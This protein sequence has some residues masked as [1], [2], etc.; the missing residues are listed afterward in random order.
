MAF[1]DVGANHGDW[2]VALLRR[3]GSDRA[4]T[5]LWA[6]EPAPAQASEAESRL[7][8]A[9][10]GACVALER[11]AVSDNSGWASFDVTGEKTGNSG[12]AG[13]EARGHLIDVPL[14]RLDE[15]PLNSFN[16]P[17]RLIKIDT[18]GNDFNV[19]KG[20]KK[21]F[22]AA[23]IEICQFEYNWRW[24]DFGYN[25]RDVFN[26]IEGRNY[27]LGAL[28]SE[29]VEIHQAWHPEL[30][31]FFETNFVLI[32]EDIIERTGANVMAFD[33]ANVAVPL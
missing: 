11:V 31:R 2:S 3:L 6:F 22:D 19:I 32:R 18:E 15:Y 8:Q 13:P 23:R 30:E 28:T 25:L 1:L 29:G 17:I 5:F 12:I 7:I 14:I 24:M 16:G 4:R 20:A 33:H 10:S 27:K 26:W 9:S 21:L